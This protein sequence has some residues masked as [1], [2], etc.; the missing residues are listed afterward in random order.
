[1]I[2]ITCR[3]WQNNCDARGSCFFYDN[4]S[5]SHNLLGVTLVGKF[6]ASL[7]FFLALICYKLPPTNQVNGKETNLKNN[8]NIGIINTNTTREGEGRDANVTV[9][10]LRLRDKTNTWSVFADGGY[11]HITMQ[12]ENGEEVKSGFR[13]TLSFSKVSGKFNFSTGFSQESD[14]WDINDLGYMRA[15]NEFRVY[16]RMNYNIYEYAVFRVCW[17]F[18]IVRIK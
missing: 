7:F 11:S 10:Q 13:N 8:S 3:L 16:G 9:G 4:E 15:P 18:K 1:M 2:D 5:M 14:T 6:F 12:G 17:C